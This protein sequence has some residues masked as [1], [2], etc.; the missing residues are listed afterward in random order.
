[1]RVD[2]CWWSSIFGWGFW[3]LDAVALPSACSDSHLIW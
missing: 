2:I 1:M 3:G